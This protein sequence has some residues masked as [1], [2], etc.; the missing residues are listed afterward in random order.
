MFSIFRK[1]SACRRPNSSWS[2]WTLPCCLFQGF[3]A[4]CKNFKLCCGKRETWCLTET[5]K[6]RIWISEN[7]Y[8]SKIA[9]TQLATDIERKQL[10]WYGHI[11]RINDTRRPKKIMEWR[12]LKRRNRRKPGKKEPFRGANGTTKRYVQNRHRT[13]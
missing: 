11:Q 2:R 13:S 4:K 7:G 8:I 6:R 1:Q 3:H 10:I 5:Y 12:Q 9:E